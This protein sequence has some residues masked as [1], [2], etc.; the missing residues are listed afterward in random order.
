[1]RATPTMVGVTEAEPELDNPASPTTVSTDTSA[2][3]LASR[4]IWVSI[5]FAALAAVVGLIA[6]SGILLP[7]SGVYSARR[8]AGGTTGIAVVGLRMIGLVIATRPQLGILGWMPKRFWGC[9]LLDLI[10]W[11]I[12]HGSIA[13]MA[14]LSIFGLFEEA[15]QRLV[16]DSIAA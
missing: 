16:V 2:A 12:I 6:F 4:A 9:W 5:S 3:R 11:V 13:T 7:I 8:I 10:G 14:I 15:F 1:L